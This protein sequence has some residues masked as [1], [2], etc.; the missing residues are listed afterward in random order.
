VRFLRRN[1]VGN[2]AVYA[3]SIVSGI[4]LTPVIVGAI[5]KGAYG[6][7][8]FVGSLMVFL[9][10]LDVGLGPAVVR[11][12]AYGRGRGDVE[13][14]SDVVSCALA[15]YLGVGVATT[16][17]GI[18]LAWFVPSLEDVH[19]ALVSPARIAAIVSVLSLALELPLGLFSNLM[20][21]Q[22]RFDVVNAGSIVSIALYA[23]R[24]GRRS[25]GSRR[26]PS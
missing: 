22:Q 9:R 7:W 8:V 19:G 10:L 20:K 14:I 13:G 21:G 4:V 6:V 17:G 3:A 12:S 18:V 11:I 25:P 15:L 2:Y 1:L 16:L 5:G 23:A 26:S 24:T